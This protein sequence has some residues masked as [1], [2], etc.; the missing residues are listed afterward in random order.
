MA[1]RS[2]G[3]IGTPEALQFL[4]DARKDPQYNDKYDFLT[5][6]TTLCGQ[7]TEEIRATFGFNGFRR[8][9][10]MTRT[11]KENLMLF[12]VD[13]YFPGVIPQSDANHETLVGQINAFLKNLTRKTKIA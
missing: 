10:I 6:M 9:L 4:R 3:D 13:K 5:A 7:R 12:Q 8:L 11:N 2:I 1:L